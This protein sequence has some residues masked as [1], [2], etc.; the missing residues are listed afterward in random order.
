MSPS[1]RSGFRLFGKKPRRKA[2]ERAVR[3]APWR[4]LTVESLEPRNLLAGD[5]A[6]TIF[7][8]LNNNGVKDGG[9]NGIAGM[10]VFVDFDRSG[11]LDIGEPSTVTNKDGDYLLTGI[12]AGMQNI[13]E[14]L[15]TGWTPSTGTANNYEVLVKN[16][17]EVKVDFYNFR[18]HVG[19]IVG[20]VWQDLN[21]DGV[22]ATD[23]TTGAFTDPPISNW[24]VFLDANNNR[25]ID[26]GEFSTLTDANGQYA[27]H[28]LAPGDYEVTEIV[29]SGWDVPRTFDSRQTVTVF[30]GGTTTAR[31]FANVNNT[32]GSIQGTVWND[33]NAD[34]VRANDPVT[35][36]Y[37]DSG[38]E[39]WTVF[40]DA[41]NNRVVDAGETRTVTDAAGNYMFTGLLAGDY[42]VTEELPVGWNVSRTFDVRQTISVAGGTLS[43]AGDFANFSNSN[44]SLRGVVWNDLNA[45]GVRA[46]DAVTGTFTD[47]ALVGW[48]VF[49]DLN[50]NGVKDAAESAALTDA[51]GGYR[52]T[53]LQVGDY[54][55]VV[56]L[57]TGWET[58][59]TF[60][61]NYTVAVFGGTQSVAH[62][63]AGHEISTA[64]P[65]T[66]SG[67]VWNDLNGNGIRDVD[68][69]TGTYSDPGLAGWNVFLDLNSNRVFD[70]TETQATTAADGTYKISN[71]APGTVSIVEVAPAGWR[72]SAPVTN[73][74]TIMVKNGQDVANQDFGNAQLRDS[75]IRGVVF[76]D[77]DKSGTRESTERGLAGV[78]VF[79]DLNENGVL[80]V[81][82]QQTV[83]SDDL[84][85][86]PDVNEAGIYS[87]AHLAGGT[88]TV[89]EILPST[90]S[91]TPVSQLAHKVAISGAEDRSG[92]DTA[93]VFR[94]NEIHGVKFNDVD[95]N[96]QQDPGEAGIAGAT[97]YVDINRNNTLDDGEL[98][99]VTGAD[100]SYVFAGLTPGAY[101]AR[102]V[103][104]AGYS[105]T[106][107]QTTDGVLLP[108]GVSNPTVGNVTPSI[109]NTSLTAGQSYRQTVSLTLPST[110]AL[111]NLVD[112]FLLFDDTGSFV[113]NSPI[114]REAFPAII[115]QLQTALP[116]IDL[117]FGVGRF[118]EYA[119]FAS[120]YSTGRPFV[121]NQPIVAA[122]T[123]GYLTAIQ[124]GLNRTTPGYGGDQPETDIEALYQLVTGKGFDGNNN[125]S[126]LDSGA[127]GLAATQLNPGTSGDVPSFA[128]FTADATNSVMAAAGT[129]GGAGFRAGALPIILTATDTGFAFQP[130]GE[131]S[132]T[133]VGGVTLPVSAL[134]QTSRPT[135]P[136]SSGAGLQETVT[137]LNA[138]GALVIGLGTNPQA[139]L[140]P[141]QGLEALSKLTGAVNH[142]TMTIDNGTTDPIA[143]G[144][145]LYF[146]IATGFASSVAN[147]V[148]SAIQNAV[149]N[150][151]VDIT[152]QASDP[153]V[154]IINHTG[155]L[156]GIG[157]GQTAT[158]DIEFVGDGAP[159]RFDL[160][161]V[162]AG[163]NVVLGSIPVVIGTPIVG[164]GYEFTELEDGQ[165]ST[166]CDF[167]VTAAMTVANTAPSFVMGADQSVAEDAASQVVIGWASNISPGPVGESSQVV[168]FVVTTNNSS[169]FSVQPGITA[170]GTL[171]YSLAPNANGIATVTVALHDDGGTAAGG[172]DMS[173]SQTFTI[174]VTAVNDAPAAVD[175]AFITAED[176]PLNIL[177]S[178]LVSNDSDIDGDPLAAVLVSGPSHG[179][180]K[181]N[182]DGSFSYT[183]TANYNG[184]DSFTY[185][186]HDGT[187]DSNLAVVSLTVTAVN[188][189]PVAANDAY[190]VKQ[191]GVLSIAAAGVLANDKDI[192]GDPLT[193]A[194]V[195][196]PSHGTLVL[197]GNGGFVY[198][199]TSGFSGTDGFTYVA[200][201][202]TLSSAVVSV[203]IQVTPSLPPSGTK[204]Y[205][206]DSS[207]RGTFGYDAA[208]GM[209]S[210]QNLNKEN[211]KPHG[212]ASNKEGTR[213]WTLDEKGDVFVYDA[214]GK[215]LGS[216]TAKGIDKPEGITTDGVNIWI[217][218]DAANKIFYFAG[219]ASR[220]S[221]KMSATTTFALDRNNA[222]PMD[223]VTDGRHLWVVNDTAKLDSVFRYTIGGKLEGSWKI[224]G[225][226]KTPTGLTIDPNNVSDIWIV[227]AGTDR[228][229]QYSGATARTSG[230]QNASSSFALAKADRNPQG[231]ADPRSLATS[232]TVT[233][234]SLSRNQTTVS[235][236]PAPT[237]STSVRPEHAASALWAESPTDVVSSSLGYANARRDL[238][239]PL[240]L[241]FADSFVAYINSLESFG[242]G[243]AVKKSTASR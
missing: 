17:T 45:D 219:A 62:D 230:A 57:P 113:N 65:G 114:V 157:A 92:V 4:K 58:A 34:G 234:D 70:P 89:R 93:A 142:S 131:T 85:F 182:A 2:D 204:F 69:A 40:L 214:A 38:L 76:A 135:T 91:A 241:T 90:L 169:L 243:K 236:T 43:T 97:V 197:G 145:P 44:G 160:Q 111:T 209:T 136:F 81:G 238:R 172:S 78:T 11:G 63:F 88:Y 205:V 201:D 154:K 193:A 16:G 225:A 167:G 190:A 50:G 184:A 25:L 68:P 118:E 199:P 53:D 98:T 196:G 140:D 212:I 177:S 217:V 156:N 19:S 128:S 109:I 235:G 233:S 73:V 232:F 31:D 108:S 116:G 64:V 200:G 179:S 115:A 129:V 35:G 79:L 168:N 223:V 144:D 55:M 133:G 95:G 26:A 13:R 192:D 6:G 48:T 61:D 110:G 237:D 164:A 23:P 3:R 102:D 191:D 87:F 49:L 37:I 161:F 132:V 178:G 187:A 10:T 104:S 46:A 176:T 27:F 228:V 141:R 96:H 101:V 152:V 171:T 124:A 15:P 117:G 226:D 1:Y 147:G 14:I 12:A 153:R 24:T 7:D 215:S 203:A 94:P 112:V 122:S 100:G 159:R 74:R 163:T 137:G 59:P 107:P 67:T 198:T 151:A 149:T 227:D 211:S 231:I 126:V 166:N 32:N 84:Y 105:P 224:D 180:L 33:V 86:T 146:Q 77:S 175:D 60:G 188:D 30:D 130:K 28:D 75:S 125:G 221:G 83:T 47:P 165:I 216:W 170:D 56:V 218:D 80:D 139:N 202:G 71:V 41:N 39:G 208:G 29:P 5:V 229:Y 242:S 66:V 42:E 162:R 121:L 183:P 134:S 158:F 72:S 155:T 222:N 9:E 189:A 99:A 240:K 8:D 20:N 82:D 18:T 138:L 194:T 123:P 106:Y 21:G 120:E 210:S 22:R 103:A 174:A 54:D 185:R 186:V 119:N 143:P 127:A 52:F 239:D 51:T 195:T 173:A 181:L 220:V 213:L 206:V 148:V 36:E 150:V 207:A